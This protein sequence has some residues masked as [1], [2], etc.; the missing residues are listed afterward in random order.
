MTWRRYKPSDTQHYYRVIDKRE[1][2]DKNL[3][4]CADC[5][6]RAGSRGHSWVRNL[7][8]RD[9]KI[10]RPGGQ[11]FHYITRPV[12][13]APQS[14][15]IQRGAVQVRCGRY[16]SLPS[17]EQRKLAMEISQGPQ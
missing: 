6:D 7:K 15:Q 13:F 10:H 8:R 11:I 14:W 4:P 1:V 9:V 3:T 2:L 17:K 12:F 5:G 16:I